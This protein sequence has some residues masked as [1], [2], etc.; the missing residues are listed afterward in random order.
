MFTL[1]DLFTSAFPML[2]GISMDA[3]TVMLAMISLGFIGLGFN[4]IYDILMSKYN[5]MLSDRMFTR[6]ISEAEKHEAYLTGMKKG[7]VMYKY[8]LG[9]RDSYIR[10][11][12]DAKRKR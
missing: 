7:S 9:M 2:N 10:S 12:M 8:H 1:E 11:A 3:G 5:G 6:S 4:I